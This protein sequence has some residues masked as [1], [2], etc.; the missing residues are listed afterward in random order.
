MAR[1]GDE[2]E[3]G[4]GASV[5]Q[6][7][8]AARRRSERASSPDH[9]VVPPVPDTSAGIELITLTSTTFDGMQTPPAVIHARLLA[10]ALLKLTWPTSWNAVGEAIN[11]NG[12][13]VADEQRHYHAARK[14]Q[15]PSVE[16]KT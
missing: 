14:R 7:S 12:V 6:L 8:D 4:R 13:K 9:D 1:M 5:A 3:V 11:R 16:T 10:A 15:T 2:D